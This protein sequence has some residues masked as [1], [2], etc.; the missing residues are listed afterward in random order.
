MAHQWFS[1]TRPKGAPDTDEILYAI[2]VLDLEE[3]LDE[4]WEDGDLPISDRPEVTPELIK[5]AKAHL[6]MDWRNQLL[7][8]IKAHFTLSNP[9]V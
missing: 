5:D 1:E 3:V 9:R 8:V 6:D 4:M 7:D 2:T